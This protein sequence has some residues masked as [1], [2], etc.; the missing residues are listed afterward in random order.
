[1]FA[2]AADPLAIVIDAG[3]ST[4]T[5]SDAQLAVTVVAPID[6]IMAS[7]IVGTTLSTSTMSSPLSERVR[8]PLGMVTIPPRVRV[9][10]IVGTAVGAALGA[11]VGTAV[12]TALGAVGAIVGAAVYSAF[13]PLQKTRFAP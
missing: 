3:A 11:V 2:F 9:G 13:G 12:G 6:V 10:A 4:V 8:T 5:S 1:M 7:T